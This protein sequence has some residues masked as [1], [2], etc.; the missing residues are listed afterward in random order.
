MSL[1]L[2]RDGTNLPPS[3]CTPPF[4]SFSTGRI[5]ADSANSAVYAV[6][7]VYNTYSL[8]INVTLTNLHMTSR[9]SCHTLVK[10]VDRCRDL[11]LRQSFVSL[12]FSGIIPREPNSAICTVYNTLSLQLTVILTNLHMV[13]RGSCHMLVRYG[14]SLYR[15]GAS[16]S[17]P[18]RVWLVIGS[19][20][21]NFMAS[22]HSS[23]ICDNQTLLSCL[24]HVLRRTHELQRG[25][26]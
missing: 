18:G 2:P 12:L 1:C 8:H 4:F 19:Q 11:S 16:R 26:G 25:L 3:T 20:L 5:C 14:L 10:N 15:T 7:T 6:Y 21:E 17:W 9:R 24:R 22:P 13:S 23:P